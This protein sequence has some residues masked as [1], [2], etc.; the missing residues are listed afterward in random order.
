VN[1]TA[2]QAFGHSEISHIVRYSLRKSFPKGRTEDFDCENETFSR[3]QS[4]D[5]KDETKVSLYIRAVQ[6]AAK[7]KRDLL[8]EVAPLLSTFGLRSDFLPSLWS[9]SHP[10]NDR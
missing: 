2:H 7:T 8:K 9:I 10:I 4:S 1:L 5:L 6:S 3:V